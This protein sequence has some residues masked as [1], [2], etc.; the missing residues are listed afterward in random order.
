MAILGIADEESHDWVDHQLLAAV[1][2]DS[3]DVLVTEDVGIHRKAKRLGLHHRVAYLAEA[4]TEVD[5]LSDKPRERCRQSEAQKLTTSTHPIRSSYLFGK[6]T[7][8][9]SMAELPIASF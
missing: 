9:S 4:L 3:V 6:I 2:A 8:T 7:Q 1:Y 5:A